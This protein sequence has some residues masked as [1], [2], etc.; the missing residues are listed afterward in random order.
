MTSRSGSSNFSQPSVP[1]FNGE[2]Y[3]YWNIM[4]K[5]LFRF[6]G[7]WEVVEKGF[8][9]EEARVAENKQNDA[10]ALFLIQQP[11]HRSMFSTIAAANTAKEAWGTLKIQFQGNPKIMAMRIQALRQTFENL[12]RKENLLHLTQQHLNAQFE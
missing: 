2:D 11:M 7:L 4:M 9:E 1:L 6:N 5:T 12:H 10:H 3:D 8:T